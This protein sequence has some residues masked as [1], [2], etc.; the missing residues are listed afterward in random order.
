M[1]RVEDTHL[2]YYRLSL[3]EVLA[4][5]HSTERGLSAAEA[6]ERYEQFGPNALNVKKRESRFLAYLRQF[7]DFMILL[8]VASSVLA[9]YL[10]DK[11][12]GSVLLALVFFNTMIGYLQEYNAE[13][14]I[15]SLEK[16]VVAK[17]KVL[18]GGKELEIASSELVVGDV[19]RIEAGDSVPADLRV[20]SE[21][22]L[23]TNDFALTGESNPTRKFKHAITS[24]VPL[25][26]RQNLVYMGTTVA[27]GVGYGVVVATGMHTE[28]GRIASL[29]QET[30]KTLSPLQLEMNNIATKVTWGT[31]ILCVILLPI[32]I[33]ADLGIKDAVLFAI[34]I[35]SSMIPQ[36]LPAEI[37][38]ALAGAA[39]QLAR[40]RALVKKLSAVETLG[41]TNVILTDK[42]GTLTKNEMTVEQLLVGKTEYT[43]TGTGYEANGVVV[44]IGGKA[45]PGKTL[46]E[47]RIV[48]EAAALASNAQVNPPDDEHGTWHVIGDPTEGALITLARK[49]GVDPLELNKVHPESKE[50]AFDSAR[51]RMSSVREYNGKQYLFVK[52]APESIVELSTSLWDH[53]LTRKLT[54]NDRKRLLEYHETHATHAQRN[55]ALAYRELPKDFD[56]TKQPLEIA[57][58][59]LTF[60][61]M[62][63][64]IDPLREEVP[65]AMVA[66]RQAHMAISIITG[67][68]AATARA[69][70]VR[71]KLA[72]K[73]EH[74]VV[75]AGEDLPGLSDEQIL[76]HVRRGGTI[77]SR[78]APED[79]LRI[80][81]LTQKSG[82]VVAVTGDGINDAPALKR[83]D[84]GVAM[85]VTGTD[86]AKQ[87]ADIVLL[88]DSFH[89]LVGA[90]QQGRTIFR[91]IQKGTVSCFTS[92][93]A[94]L[95]ANLASLAAA[96]LFH[97]PLA[98]TVMQILAIDLIAE[99]FPLAALGRDKAE[100]KLMREAPRNL[101]HHILNRV[102]ITDFVWAGVLMGGLAFA[103]YLLF[104]WRNGV[105]ASFIEPGSDLHMAATSM[106]YLTIVLCQLANILQRRSEHGLFTRY[107]FHNRALWGAYA[108]SLVLVSLIIYSPVNTYFGSAPLG[109]MDWLCAI[110]AAVIFIFVRE[111]HLHA[112]H[113][114]RA[115]LFSRHGH[116]TVRKHLQRV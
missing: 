103:N 62:V 22:E 6:A 95:A 78:V 42:T 41:A 74:L 94:E 101:K 28:L 29:S 36:G 44:N 46:E 34:G 10:G 84:I 79:K 107:Q 106:T 43:V 53:S 49:G 71:A 102:S 24:N 70:A 92:N 96:A 12:A 58:Q 111:L 73:P 19:V 18:R 9:F 76:Q 23:S 2:H 64:M 50:Y 100:G 93:Y 37:N 98:I 54:A 90:V 66:A 38:T 82:F 86:V 16:L 21:D 17:A 11:R 108:L 116:E 47:L 39:G 99:I 105:A 89:T 1:E 5:V 83:A 113:H 97:V 104:Y 4:Q 52:G 91:N 7:K 69:I 109:V 55:L 51:K 85:G 13:K 57:E 110:L 32:A 61:G 60:L 77:F 33:A 72:D 25:S 45:I 81:E 40:A 20:L 87:S 65:A 8:L 114:S 35:A 27:T 88:D 56:A 59:D 26:S 75:V 68:F 115:T 48:F 112:G 31:I 67:D 80:V 30:K 63:S 14:L 3:D 15:E